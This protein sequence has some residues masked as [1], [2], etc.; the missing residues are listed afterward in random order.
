MADYG[1]WIREPDGQNTHQAF[2][3]CCRLD[4]IRANRLG[5]CTQK[6]EEESNQWPLSA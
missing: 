3:P 5:F 2:A 6:S 1:L 4:L